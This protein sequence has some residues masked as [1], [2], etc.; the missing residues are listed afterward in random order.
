MNHDVIEDHSLI[1][2]PDYTTRRNSTKLFSWAELQQITSGDGIP[3]TSQLKW[4]VKIIKCWEF[5]KSRQSSSVELSCKSD[6]ITIR[7]DSSKQLSRV[8]SGDVIAL[9]TQ[10]NIT[11]VI[12]SELYTFYVQRTSRSELSDQYECTQSSPASV[13]A[14]RER[15]T[16][17]YLKKV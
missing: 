10:L 2:S 8:G 12:W 17:Q 7:S 14:L 5:P 13:S 15:L 4:I 16:S 1:L 6:H 9:K 11:V 3:P